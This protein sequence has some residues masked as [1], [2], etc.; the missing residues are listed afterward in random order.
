MVG[1]AAVIGSFGTAAGQEELQP[2]NYDIRFEPTAKLQTGVQVPFQITVRDPLQKPLIDAKVTLR[3]ET[4]TGEKTDLFK[5]PATDPGVYLAKPVFPTAGQW[6][7]TADVR[8][9]NKESSRTI[10]FNVAQ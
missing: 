4:P 9:D 7:V 8:R 1:L 5:A 6:N 3:I 10:E 2:G